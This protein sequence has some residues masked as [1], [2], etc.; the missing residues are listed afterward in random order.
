MQLLRATA[1]EIRTMLL[2]A[3]P[4]PIRSTSTQLSTIRVLRSRLRSPFSP[5]KPL[6]C[7]F[8]VPAAVL[9][10]L[11]A[12][13]IRKLG[14]QPPNPHPF[15]YFLARNPSRLH[16]VHDLSRHH[17]VQNAGLLSGILSYLAM[18]APP[19]HLEPPCGGG[20]PF[21]VSGTLPFS[22]S[23]SLTP[24]STVLLKSDRFLLS[25]N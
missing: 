11:A 24:I 17:E 10:F 9:Q 15:L 21:A 19:F 2:L 16:I 6:M 20:I 4:S 5:E 25:W 1:F 22:L 8:R 7:C 18:L 13:R 3:R 12:T 14:I 23:M